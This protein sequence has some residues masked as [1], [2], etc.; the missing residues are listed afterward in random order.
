MLEI[1]RVHELMLVGFLVD[2][3]YRE[4]GEVQTWCDPLKPDEREA[5]PHRTAQRDVLWVVALSAAPLVALV[6]VRTSFVCIWALVRTS[7]EDGSKAQGGI[8]HPGLPDAALNVHQRD[9]L[10]LELETRNVLMADRP[11]RSQL[12]GAEESE[13]RGAQSFVIA[14]LVD[15]SRHRQRS[16]WLHAARQVEGVQLQSRLCAGSDL[17]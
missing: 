3:P 14:V 13:S 15:A 9:A 4:H 5:A 6:A 7:G 1:E 2:E 10:A 8:E 16:V 17:R 11:A 12:H